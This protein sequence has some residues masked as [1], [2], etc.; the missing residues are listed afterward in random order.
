MEMLQRDNGEN[1]QLI[2][3]F[4]NESSNDGETSSILFYSDSTMKE[5][6]YEIECG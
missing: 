1:E 6:T 4:F 5:E 2:L 3:S